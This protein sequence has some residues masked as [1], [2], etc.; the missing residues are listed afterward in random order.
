MKR[1]LPVYLFLLLTAVYVLLVILLPTD[2]ATL[3]KYHISQG[4]ARLLNLTVVL[5][6]AVIWYLALNGFM[7]FWQ[8]SKVIRNTNEG[9]SFTM[10]AYGLMILAFSLPIN[11][12]V[13]AIFNYISIH[14]PNFL[15][16]AT[17]LRNYTTLL[18][19][20]VSFG[21]LARG[22]VLLVISHKEKIRYKPVMPLFM[23]PLMIILTSVFTWLVV[24]NQHQLS[25]GRNSYYLPSWLVVTTIVI[26][27]LVAWV[28]GILSI[29]YIY[30]YH[31][32]VKGAV[33]KQ[34]FS[35]L[36]KGLALVT[37]ISVFVQL[38]VTITEQINRLKLTPIL[39][40]IY[41][42]VILYAIGFWYI[43]HGSKK[44]QTFEEV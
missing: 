16:T 4:Q 23:A 43:A 44:L 24:A 12:I 21:L 1:S 5:P 14:N 33:Y 38:L 11:S 3:A 34:A 20:L 6:L 13:S 17:V 10:L 8:Y 19:A 22:A 35:E 27:Y 26:P 9:W 29:Y 31:Q 40:L 42:L 7:R 18:L 15:P 36:A 32:K 28:A 25:D 39:L 41:L 37:F 30:I 2:P